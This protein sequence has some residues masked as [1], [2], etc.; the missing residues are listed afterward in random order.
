MNAKSNLIASAIQASSGFAGLSLLCVYRRAGC[1]VA[2][3]PGRA[4]PVEAESTVPAAALDRL[5]HE[6]GRAHV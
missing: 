4:T 3:G 6:I 5:A 2:G 1:S